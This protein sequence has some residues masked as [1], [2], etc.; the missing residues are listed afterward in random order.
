LHPDG[1]NEAIIRMSCTS[2]CT[3]NP[4]KYDLAAILLS[5][6]ITHPDDHAHTTPAPLAVPPDPQTLAA[7]ADAVRHRLSPLSLN[8]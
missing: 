8:G 4:K 6:Q 1:E 2:D 7:Q 3:E 5:L